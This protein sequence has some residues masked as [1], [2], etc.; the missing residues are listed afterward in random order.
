MTPPG[1][2]MLSSQPPWPRPHLGSRFLGSRVVPPPEPISCASPPASEKSTFAENGSSSLPPPRPPA[3]FHT[4]RITAS[5][6]SKTHRGNQGLTSR[7]SSHTWRF[8]R[9]FGE[10]RS[11][12]G[13]G[14][15]RYF[16]P[17]P[18]AAVT[19]S[20]ES[21]K[22][23][24]ASFSLTLVRCTQGSPPLPAEKCPEETHPTNFKLKGW[25]RGW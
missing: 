25:G 17:Q 12:I 15:S 6:L 24:A 1:V 21:G 22:K 19:G 11:E 2:L 20:R 4:H 3:P 8:S 16:V 7:A 10:R 13:N 14:F 5:L 23:P 18:S 9:Y